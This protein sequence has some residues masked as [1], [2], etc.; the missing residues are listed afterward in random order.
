M[1]AGYSGDL[2]IDTSIRRA[3]LFGTAITL[4]SSPARVGVSKNRHRIES[5]FAGLS[6]YCASW[7]R[8]VSCLPT[9]TSAVHTGS[10]TRVSINVTVNGM[11]SLAMYVNVSFDRSEPPGR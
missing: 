5:G 9:G 6:G 7:N 1:P 11:C 8:I 2:R 10:F 4:P 3:N